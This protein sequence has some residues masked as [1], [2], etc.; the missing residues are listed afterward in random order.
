MRIGITLDDTDTDALNAFCMATGMSPDSDPAEWLYRQINEFISSNVKAGFLHQNSADA[1]AVYQQA[2]L[3]AV[4]E[5]TAQ[6]GQIDITVGSDVIISPP[7]KVP[8]TG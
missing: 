1:A 7:I 4:D 5:A 3:V 2:L 6:L 8:P